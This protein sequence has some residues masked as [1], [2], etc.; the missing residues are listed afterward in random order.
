VAYIPVIRTAQVSALHQRIW[1]RMQTVGVKISDHYAPEFWMPH[2]SLAYSD[3]TRHSLSCLVERLGF[4]T[5]NWEIRIDNLA[6]IYEP[7]GEIGAIR[8]QFS[9]IDKA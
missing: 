2:I 4:H 7:E 9:L 6:L 8:Y 1:E 3:I 5:Y